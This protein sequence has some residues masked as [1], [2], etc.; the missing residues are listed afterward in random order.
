MNTSKK[1][2]SSKLFFI[3]KSTENTKTNIK[4]GLAAV[5]VA[6][7][8]K[9]ENK[10]PQNRDNIFSGAAVTGD[11]APILIFFLCGF[12]RGEGV[13]SLYDNGFLKDSL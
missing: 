10:T 5:V 2:S 13:E 7:M 12:C 9:V 3:Q 8:R 11:D 1:Y 6:C 4:L